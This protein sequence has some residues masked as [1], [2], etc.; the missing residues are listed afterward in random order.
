MH[1]RSARRN[2]ILRM[3]VCGHDLDPAI[4][5]QLRQRT[6]PTRHIQHILMACGSDE[7]RNLQTR[8][9]NSIGTPVLRMDMVVRYQLSFTLN[10]EMTQ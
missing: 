1:T 6:R 10:L 3:E 5:E 2:E 8:H 9:P 7:I 4:D